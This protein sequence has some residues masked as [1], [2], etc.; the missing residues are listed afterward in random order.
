MGA[1]LLELPVAKVMHRKPK[2][3]PAAA[4]AVDALGLMNRF[5]ITALFIVDK[6]RRPIGFLHMHDCLRAGVA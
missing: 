5:A 4:F 1:E 2:T 3:I 6:D